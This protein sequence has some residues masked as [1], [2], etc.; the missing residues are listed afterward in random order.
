MF[1]A[2]CIFN[3]SASDNVRIVHG[4]SSFNGMVVGDEP[5]NINHSVALMLLGDTPTYYLPLQRLE[6]ELHE[7]L[8]GYNDAV[9]ALFRIKTPSREQQFVYS[10][11]TAFGPT[12]RLFIQN[13][14][15]SLP[16]ELLDEEGHVQSL[17]KVMAHYPKKVLTIVKGRSYGPYLD[18]QLS[19]LDEHQRIEINTNSVPYL[20]AR[21]FINK[22]TDFSVLFPDEIDEA[23]DGDSSDNYNSYAFS[24]APALMTSHIAC[25]KTPAGITFVERI[26]QQI[27]AL[28]K[29]R[30]FIDAHGDFYPEAEVVRIAQEIDKYRLNY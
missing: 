27:L 29:T 3:A 6:H 21:L 19:L 1:A 10:L 26:N 12:Q 22:R 5:T 28:Y 11:P 23:S 13:D 4:D 20:N 30:D 15:P 7:S 9:C 24:G 14:L 25:N 18:E 2:V 16:V 8:I 17:S